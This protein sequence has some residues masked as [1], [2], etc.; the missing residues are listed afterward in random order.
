MHNWCYNGTCETC[1]EKP[2]LLKNQPI[3]MY[4]CP[5]CAMLLVAGIRHL[6]CA[7]SDAAMLNGHVEI[8]DEPVDI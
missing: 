4:H 6:T 3:G 1:P 8:S 7:E 5:Y 2:E